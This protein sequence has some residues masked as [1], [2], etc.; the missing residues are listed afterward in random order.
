MSDSNSFVMRNL[1]VFI[2]VRNFTPTSEQDVSGRW[3]L[4]VYSVR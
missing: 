3:T 1:S 4:L 2:Q